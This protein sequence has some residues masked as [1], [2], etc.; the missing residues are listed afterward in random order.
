MYSLKISRASAEAQ[1]PPHLNLHNRQKPYVI[2]TIFSK[3][4][5]GL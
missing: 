2:A 5:Y 4:T 3:Q 1:L